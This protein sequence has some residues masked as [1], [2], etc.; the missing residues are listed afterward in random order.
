MLKHGVFSTRQKAWNPPSVLDL[1]A[2]PFCN[3]LQIPTSSG[4]FS[5]SASCQELCNN[6]KLSEGLFCISY[7]ATTSCSLTKASC[8]PSQ[9]VK[10]WPQ[11]EV[12][13]DHLSYSPG[14]FIH[15][16]APTRPLHPHNFFLCTFSS[17]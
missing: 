9:A 11:A 15:P 8:T 3:E 7:S 1:K 2:V 10:M 13:G 4:A 5:P 6:R 17:R 12:G 16:T 14:Y